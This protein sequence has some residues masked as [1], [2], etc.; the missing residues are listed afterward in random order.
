M[1]AGDEFQGELLEFLHLGVDDAQVVADNYLISSDMSSD[2]AR[3]AGVI[4]LP[5]PK[6]LAELVSECAAQDDGAPSRK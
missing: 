4:H 3:P 5:A 2:S 6:Q 1:A